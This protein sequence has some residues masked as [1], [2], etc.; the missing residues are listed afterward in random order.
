M[1]YFVIYLHYLILMKVLFYEINNI[2][3]NFQN[4]NLKNGIYCRSQ[5]MLLIS[6][7]LK[8]ANGQTADHTYDMTNN[9]LHINYNSQCSKV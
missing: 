8:A 3:H 2:C 9:G 4:F 7:T 6:I 5:K 1:S